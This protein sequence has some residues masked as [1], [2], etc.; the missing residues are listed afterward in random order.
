MIDLLFS[1]QIL[2]S[3]A[4]QEDCPE[5]DVTCDLMLDTPKQESSAQ[6]IA[7]ETGVFYGE[8]FFSA[9]SMLSSV[10]SDLKCQDGDA[11]D[12]GDV[13]AILTGP[14]ADLL[15]IER[16]LLNF[17]QRLCGIASKTRLFVTALDDNTISILDTRKTTPLFRSLEREAVVAGGGV[18]HRLNLSDMVLIKENHLT[19]Y[20]KTHPASELGTLFA[21][22][23][24]NNP[25][26]KIE[27]EIETLSQLNAYDLSAVDYIL[28]DNF[29]IS[30]IP[31]AAQ[32]C[33]ERGF[34][35][36]IEIS[37]NVTL[38]TIQ[39]YRGLPIDR[40]SVGSLTHSVKATDLSLLI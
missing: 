16:V 24:K 3:N 29:A 9:V 30:D 28:L 39:K 23:K 32:I 38:D 10:R 5:G 33:S 19:A 31:N 6:L 4:L 7:K 40:I 25:D 13:I 11:F 37:G 27:I 35:A 36:E 14:V 20:L 34:T 1:T 8:V 26:K 18:N 21:N 17:L 2:F 15:K 22:F 12:T